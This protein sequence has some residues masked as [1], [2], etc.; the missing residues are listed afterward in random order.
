[1]ATRVT[2]ISEA[3]S[4]GERREQRVGRIA[5]LLLLPVVILLIIGLGALL[6]ASSV[7]AIR[8]GHLDNLFYFKI[9]TFHLK[10]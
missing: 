3:R 7:Q 4:F 1:M 9:P 5:V 6:S 2:P 8:D 10:S